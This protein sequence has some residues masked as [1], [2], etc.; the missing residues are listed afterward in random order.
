MKQAPTW[1]E[2]TRRLV[3][4][5]RSGFCRAVICRICGDVMVKVK[6]SKGRGWRE[7]YFHCCKVGCSGQLRLYDDN[8]RGEPKRKIVDWS[9]RYLSEY[10]L[11]QVKQEEELYGIIC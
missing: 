8:R 7:V 2:L 1:S 10:D 5:V 9:K 4:A 3:F 11:A 6:D